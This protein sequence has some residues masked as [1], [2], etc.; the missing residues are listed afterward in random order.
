MLKFVYIVTDVVVKYLG[1]PCPDWL[2]EVSESVSDNF[3]LEIFN[4]GNFGRKIKREN[5]TGIMTVKDSEKSTFKRK[6]KAMLHA[7]NSTNHRL[8]P[9]LD[10]LPWL[11][12][13]IMLWRM[14]RYIVLMLCGKRA[15][16][17]RAYKYADSRSRQFEEFE[18]FQTEE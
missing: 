14:L 1:V 17:T 3:I 4:G 8:Y 7:L 5:A 6:V 9:I 12:P 10:K 16:L 11:Y 15:S 2:E 13:F 18:L